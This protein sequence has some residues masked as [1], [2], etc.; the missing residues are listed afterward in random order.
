[1]NT[2]E[3]TKE[4]LKTEFEKK[5]MGKLHY[6]VSME[7]EQDCAAKTILLS[8][9]NYINKILHRLNLKNCKP[10]SMPCGWADCFIGQVD[11]PSNAAVWASCG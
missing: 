2:I 6:L 10:V 11:R 1:M 4:I 9:K 7:I 8:Q 3:I 5:D